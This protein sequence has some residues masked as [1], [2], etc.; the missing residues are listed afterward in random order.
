MELAPGVEVTPTIRLVKKLGEGG[1]GSVWI[2][3]H[4]ALHTQVAVKFMAAHFATSPDAMARFSREASAA[5]QIKS[6][7]VVQIFDHGVLPGGVPFIVM[8]LLEGEE[9][10]QLMRRQGTVGV[11]QTSQI[12][13]QMCKA[14][15]KAHA[16]GVIHRDIKPDNVF[17]VDS[18]GEIFVKLLDFGIAKQTQESV[19]VTSTGSVMGTP[20]YM[21]PEQL[22]SSK[23]VDPRSDLWAVGVVAYHCITGRVPFDGETFA[24]IALAI[25]QG[26]YP[27]PF[28]SQGIGSPELDAWFARALS[29]TVDGRFSSAR[30]LAEELAKLA[31]TPG[32]RASQYSISEVQPNAFGSSPAWQDPSRPSLPAVLPAPVQTASPMTFNGMAATQPGA[33]PPRRGFLIAAIAGAAAIGLLGIV[34]AL[35][36]IGGKGGDPAPG[37]AAASAPAPETT[38]EPEQAPSASPA[39]P[40]PASGQADE[41]KPA[42]PEPQPEPKATASAAATAAP[43]AAPKPTAVRRQKDRG[44]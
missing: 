13:S 7:H 6:P 21:S 25:A 35:V 38:L 4:L 40:E 14:L 37:T 31:S 12:I 32:A 33:A 9:L 29:R 10:S 22:L 20:H 17:L 16:R 43:A 30:E 8:E 15:A 26:E 24:G 1:M 44:F 28:A 3:D 18:D 39:P 23:H 2:A 27:P 36:S 5:A 34:I 11:E 41:T 19:H 42:G